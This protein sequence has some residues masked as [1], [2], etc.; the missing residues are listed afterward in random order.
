MVAQPVRN[1]TELFI[2]LWSVRAS[3]RVSGIRLSVS[4][5][6]PSL[7]LGCLETPND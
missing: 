6:D 3:M 5:L 2:A 4:T 1:G 7:Y